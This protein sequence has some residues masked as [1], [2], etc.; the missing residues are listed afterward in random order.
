[1]KLHWRKLLSYFPASLERHFYNRYF[2]IDDR[3]WVSAQKP[4]SSHLQK[5]KIIRNVAVRHNLEVLVETGT[6][7]GDMIY[8][9]LPHF[10]R[11]Y[12]IELS[13]HFYKQACQRFKST[14]NVVL[15]NG[16]SSIKLIDVVKQLEQPAVFW[17]DGH[18]SGGITAKGDKECPVYEEI[19][20]IF[21]SSLPHIILIDD[22][23]LFVGANDY[24]QLQDFEFYVHRQK[25]GYR[26]F[27]ENDIIQII[28]NK[29][30][31]V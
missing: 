20:S 5:Q 29:P 27:V 8:A 16:D 31:H 22:A 15:L 3:Q 4:G 24:P 19:E 14:R 23:R 2:S 30:E 9:M 6:F 13:N 7:M 1:M 28:P 21:Q 26:F 17:L 12:S 11:L 18:Y 25:P 10:K